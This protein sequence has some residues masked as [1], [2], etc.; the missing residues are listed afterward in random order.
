MVWGPAGQMQLRRFMM[1]DGSRVTDS[2]RGHSTEAASDT[3]N[4]PT[5]DQDFGI[6]LGKST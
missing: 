5:P 2:S 3:V 4:E 6:G 1:G